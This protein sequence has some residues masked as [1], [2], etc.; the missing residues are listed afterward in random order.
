MEDCHLLV[1]SAISHTVGLFIAFMYF[2]LQLQFVMD[3]YGFLLYG[4]IVLPKD[5]LIQTC[6]VKYTSKL[7]DE[8]GLHHMLSSVTRQ[9]LH[10]NECGL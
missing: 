7:C 8:E 9:S 3:I 5:V 6:N 10:K 2:C 4:F 1:V